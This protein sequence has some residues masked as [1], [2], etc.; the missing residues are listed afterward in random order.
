MTEKLVTSNNEITAAS[1]ALLSGTAPADI[2]ERNI[3]ADTV[4]HFGVAVL[5][6]EKRMYPY[7]AGDDTVVPVAMKKR[8]GTGA[9]KNFPSE[10]PIGETML[11][12]QHCFPKGGKYII[13]TEGEDDAMSAYQMSGKYP[14]VSVR[15]ASTALSDCQRNYDFLDSFDHV[16]VMF[17]ADDPGQKA[18]AKVAQLF[19]G[20]S[21]VAK[22]GAPFKD[23]S[24]YLK[25][26]AIDEFKTAFWRAETYTPDGIVAACDLWDEVSRPLEKAAVLYPWD[27]LNAILHGIRWAEL[28]TVASGSGMGKSNLLREILWHIL[29][30]SDYKIGG[31]FMEENPRKTGLSL[32]SMAANKLLHLPGTEYTPAEFK[33]AYDKTLGTER[34]YL[35]DHFGSTSL[36]NIVARCRYMVRAVGCKILFVDHVSIIVSA[37]E[38]GDERKA[39]DEIMTRLRMLV[40]ELD[41][42]LFLVSHLKRP[43]GKGHEEGARTSLAHLRGSAAIAQLS[44]IVLGL[45]RN[46]QADDPD[47]RNTTLCRVLKNRFSGELGPACR[48]QYDKATGRLSEVPDLDNDLE[49]AL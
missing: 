25:G 3:K 27:G 14:A 30:Y 22:F 20:K 42:A 19:G 5:G 18:A 10:G 2:P 48:L 37:Q 23:A 16:V 38:H 28:V 44:D 17:D 31:L 45:E 7:F 21:K 8:L 41:V 11:F 4:A 36:D 33:E 6:R 9:Q 34:I 43:E 24:D 15:N 40:Q 32:M 35:F 46:S 47:E 12:G 13:V 39:I 29:Q 1:L 26:G 49:E